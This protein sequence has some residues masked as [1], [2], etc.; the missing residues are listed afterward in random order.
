MRFH[1][2]SVT[3]R[4]FNM[5]KLAKLLS[6]GLVGT[7]AMVCSN[8]AQSSYAYSQQAMLPVCEFLDPPRSHACQVRPAL[9]Q[10]DMLKYR[11]ELKLFDHVDEIQGRARI[12]LRFIQASKQF[13]L[14][15]Q[16]IDATGKGMKV[17]AVKQAGRPLRFVHESNRLQI[18]LDKEQQAGTQARVEILYSGVP[19]A[20]LNIGKNKFGERVFFADNWPHYGRAWLPSIDHPSDKAQVEFV[21]EAPKQYRVVAN[22]V[23][24]SEQ[25]IKPA[26]KRSHWRED[27][28][29]PV[30]VMVVGAAPFAVQHSAT[31]KDINVSSWVFAQNKEAGFKDYSV[32]VEPLKFFDQ[33]IGAYPYKKLAN[34]QSKTRFGGLENANTIFYSEASVTGK[35]DQELLIAHEIAHQWFGNAITEKDWH[36]VWISEGFATYFAN[37]YIEHRYGAERFKLRL[38]DDKKKALDFLAKQQVAIVSPEVQ[39]VAQLLNPITYQK[40]GWVLHM[41][42]SEIGDEVF[43]RGIRA[44]YAAYKNK[45]AAT[46]DFQRVMQE[47]SGRDLTQ[48]FQQWIYRAD[49]PILKMDW[50]QSSEQQPLLIQLQQVQ[51]QAA[52]EFPLQI[53]I[54]YAD[55][56]KTI[57]QVQLKEKQQQFHFSSVK[58][59]VQV[60]LDPAMRVFFDVVK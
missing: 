15:L 12:D 20:G 1:K 5:T 51:T 56:S 41:L 48:F 32:A 29:L 23:L 13:S 44:Y 39:Q 21:V 27:V 6:G 54:E 33:H 30:K 28:A 52:F 18:L 9:T 2:D 47:T 60:S 45:N 26:R 17:L 43:W 7:V 31:Y 38:A 16:S 35:G 50:N 24:V 58:R 42:R 40:A 57:E 59:V 55:G 46:E 36:Q 10:I 4:S 49:Y 34:V 8:L 14:D 22:G 25:A 37:L 19:Q 53:Q 3:N 11:F